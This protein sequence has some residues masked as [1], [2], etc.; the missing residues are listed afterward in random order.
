MLLQGRPHG[1]CLVIYPDTLG[2]GAIYT[3]T[4]SK[5]FSALSIIFNDIIIYFF[6]VYIC[7]V[8]IMMLIV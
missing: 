7:H 4:V 2:G 3:K 1:E 5:R 6:S 8:I